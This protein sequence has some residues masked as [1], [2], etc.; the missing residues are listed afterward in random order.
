VYFFALDIV[1]RLVPKMDD[2]VLINPLMNLARATVPAR[3]ESEPEKRNGEYASVH[4]YANSNR[5]TMG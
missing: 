1:W 4:R 2:T 5:T 3:K